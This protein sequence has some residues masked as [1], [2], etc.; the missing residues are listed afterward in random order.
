VTWPPPL[1]LVVVGSAAVPDALPHAV[2]E[3]LQARLRTPVR[4]GDPFR[5]PEP[6]GPS[7]TPGALSSNA[8]VDALIERSGPAAD[9]ARGWVLGVTGH[10]LAAPRRAYVF[11][12][13]TLGGGWAIVST[14]R[15][16]GGGPLDPAALD[17]VTKEAV[18]ELGHLA[19]L[20]HC[21][22]PGCVM[23][24]SRTVAEVDAKDSHFCE[25][26]HAA[27]F[28]GRSLDPAEDEG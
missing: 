9:P 1:G 25:V 15:L 20:G 6:A 19:G 21:T 17:R 3:R 8:L 11:G 24:P 5:L 7:V 14:A 18:H 16:T 22:S 12:E 10:Q 13:A 27:F 26:C 2:A 23:G 4:I 28:R